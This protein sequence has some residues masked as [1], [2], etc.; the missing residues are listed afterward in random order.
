MEE[1]L[2]QN[3]WWENCS[4]IMRFFPK[5]QGINLR[6]IINKIDIVKEWG[7]DAIEI[8]A[9]YYG[10]VEYSGLD[11]I[12]YYCVDP[13]IGN[14][15]DFLELVAQCHENG[16]TIIAFINLGYC[17][18]ECP[19]FLKAC[20]DMRKG[21]DS[22]E[23]HRFLWSDTGKEKLDKSLVPY[24]MNDVDGHWCY[25]ERA[26]KYYWV[27]WKGIDGNVE[28]PQFNFG[29]NVWQ[30]ECKRVVDFWAGTGID[31][32]IIDAV[33]WYIN[34]N[35]QI[36]NESIT[37][38]IHEY[39]N[40]YIQPEGAGGFKDDPVQWISMGRYN[41][42]QDYGISIWWTDH[43]VIG[44][45]IESGNPSHI[46]NALKTYHDRVVE[47][48]G[49]TYIGPNWARKASYEQRLLECAVIS[50]IGELFHD[51]GKIF[52]LKWPEQYKAELKEI[53]RTL[54]KYPALQA[55]GS[56]EKLNTNNDDKYYA[57]IR[58]SID[59]EQKI[60]VVLNFQKEC[61][62]IVVKLKRPMEFIDIFSGRH[63][64][65]GNSFYITLPGYGYGI[66]LYKRQNDFNK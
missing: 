11:V 1:N 61:E 57:F 19:V 32:M 39:P 63:M 49:V 31:G 3:R 60:L 55:P 51:G 25:S 59:K 26:G 54:Q 30:D 42:V 9:P 29:D 40:Q 48:G 13:A 18:M 45:A 2:L 12:N 44:G 62:D 64:S 52:D 14:M 28:L 33:N 37:D 50:T 65:S 8:F 16:M 43:D 23:A 5:K 21:I 47:A 35:W 41:S 36:N 24:F 20:D 56:R 10:G 17:A 27:K 58:T 4:G 34:C 15:A 6:D 46:E 38:I 66:Y 22:L 53:I 7:F